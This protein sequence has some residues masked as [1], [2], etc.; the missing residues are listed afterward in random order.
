VSVYRP[1]FTLRWLAIGSVL[2]TLQVDSAQ[3][4]DYLT[5]IKPLFQDRCT[6]CHGGLKQ[7]GGL[8]LDTA[9]LIVQGGD[10]GSSV[11]RDQVS[12]SLLIERITSEDSDQRMPPEDEGESLTPEQVALI[13]QWISVGAPGPEDEQPET[14]PSDHWAFQKIIRPAVPASNTQW[15]KNPIDAFLNQR[16]RDFDLTP[17]PEAARIILLRRL[18]VDLLG[19]PPSLE[20]I[21]EFETDSSPDWFENR[22][23]RLMDDPRHGQRW[24]R[25]WMD[26]WR[27]SDWWGLGQQLRSSQKHIWHWRDWIVQSL[28][29]DTPYDEM[30]RLMLAADEL[31]PNDL[32]KLRATGFLARNFT[33]FNRAQWMDETVEHV[34]KGF[35][36]LT[37]NCARCHDH[38]FDPIDQADYYR[39]RAFFEPY[40]VRMDMLPGESDLVQDGIPRV[41]DGLPDQPTYRYIR[42]DENNPDKSEII[43]PGVPSLLAFNELNIAPID[44]PDEAWQP[45]RRSWVLNAYLDSAKNRVTIAQAAASLASKRNPSDLVL[46][47]VAD[48][49]LEFRLA[50]L[51]SVERR[52]DAL[53]YRWKDASDDEAESK[54]AEAVQAERQVAVA[55]AR[56]EV[57][58][59]KLAISKTTDEKR[60]AAE[61]RLQTANDSLDKAIAASK[62]EVKP[63]DLFTPLV[64]AKWTP[65]RFL[66]SGKDDPKAKFLPTSTGRRT[67]L[68]NWIT[69]RRNPLTARVVVNHIWTRHMGQPLVPTMFDFGR[70]GTAPNHPELLDWLAAELMDN[71]WSMKHL[72]RLIVSSAAYRMSS[73]VANAEHNVARDPENR[74]WWRRESTQIE[75]QVVRD[76]L[77]SLAGTLDSRLD[78]PPVPAGQQATST[79][80]SLY[81]FHSNNERNLFLTMFDEALVKD[82]YRREQSIV[83]QQ[84]LALANSSLA[85]EA[86]EVIAARLSSA[87]NEDD[88]FIRDAFAVVLGIRASDA[89]IAASKE[90]L[91]AWRT[92]KRRARSNLIWA[93]INH[94]DFVTIR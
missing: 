64:G 11:D 86:A 76:S 15:V 89:E 21:E 59:A 60:E 31:F 9:Q 20:E 46:S 81:F 75:S 22:V 40:L 35:L 83:P 28:N 2:L 36:G 30:V 49:E 69:D 66:F 32:D 24:A 1:T 18:S 88:A 78:G 65:T 48:L 51:I 37:M 63:S 52:A 12:T 61:K 50:E 85:L 17:V 62:V 34:G 38:K 77:L 45:E 3:A 4:V 44:L 43:A 13:G 70:N 27:Y 33:L 16:H 68:A 14:D 53:N 93:L 74:Y 23:N 39:L 19:L 91:N 56:L 10:S 7:E 26:V 57:A 92:G 84:A 47:T 25:H 42:G 79:R 87:E 55:K 58:K 67:A 90:A 94:N 29:N 72:H 41:F 82:C 8:R 5:E 73:S 71:D 6:V 80:R 54:N